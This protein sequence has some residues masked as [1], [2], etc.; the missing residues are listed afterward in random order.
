MT[1]LEAYRKLFPTRN[2]SIQT[3]IT[4]VINNGILDP[5]DPTASAQYYHQEAASA[6]RISTAPKLEDALAELLEVALRMACTDP[7][8]RNAPSD[9]M[10]QRD[11]KWELPSTGTY[12]RRDEDN[13]FRFLNDPIQHIAE[14]ASL[15][16]SDPLFADLS[17]PLPLVSRTSG[18]RFTLS[19][20]GG[21]RAEI[22]VYT[23]EQTW[24]GSEHEITTKPLLTTKSDNLEALIAE[25]EQV[26]SAQLATAARERRCGLLRER[27]TSRFGEPELIVQDRVTAVRYVDKNDPTQIHFSRG[28]DEAEALAH[29]L[30]GDWACNGRWGCALHEGHEGDHKPLSSSIESSWRSVDHEREETRRRKAAKA[31]PSATEAHDATPS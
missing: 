20:L 1:T 26:L 17:L 13:P 4:V 7:H 2:V 16:V 22:V 19:L 12:A 28:G 6:G 14:I 5:N 30:N 31:V 18:P 15:I 21:G 29:G 25:L 9:V 3:G 23:Q 11:H 10:C 24:N 27:F 8:H